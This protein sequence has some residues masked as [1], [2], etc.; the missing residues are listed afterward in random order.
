MLKLFGFIPI[1]LN[2]F[3]NS[4]SGLPSA[5]GTNEAVQNFNLEIAG[6]RKRLLR[7]IAVLRSRKG[8]A[9]PGPSLLRVG[10]LAG[11]VQLVAQRVDHR[12]GQQRQAEQ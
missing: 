10:Q 4:Q 2:G 12:P 5:A 1:S 11:V 6:R 7:A 3:V 8:R 9:L